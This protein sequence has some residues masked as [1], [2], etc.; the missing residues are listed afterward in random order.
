MCC[1]DKTP[2]YS[3][4]GIAEIQVGSRSRTQSFN[5]QL[6]LYSCGECGY[7]TC[8]KADFDAHMDRALHAAF[9]AHQM[10]HHVE[11]AHRKNMVRST[12]FLFLLI[13][14]AQLINKLVVV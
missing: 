7:A 6:K 3:F 8:H 10:N 1:V 14:F 4:F 11:G 5:L 12:L 9:D 2:I 13:N